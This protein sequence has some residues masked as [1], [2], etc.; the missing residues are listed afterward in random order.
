[1]RWVALILF[2]LIGAVLVLGTAVVALGA[3]DPSPQQ[4]TDAVAAWM[5]GVL[6]APIA[7]RQVVVTTA[8]F[9]T[10]DAGEYDP[11]SD[12]IRLS[13]A[14]S[15]WSPAG[16][17]VRIH[18]LAHREETIAGCYVQGEEA[19]VD[20]VDR[21]LFPAAMRHFFPAG[22]A[23]GTPHTSYDARGAWGPSVSDVRYAVMRATG[24]RT[25]DY[26]ARSYLRR[27]WGA[28]CATRASMLAV[29]A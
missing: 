10:D 3:T 11:V 2:C 6:H 20:A 21:D 18:E 5:T 8:M 12:Q 16:L 4:S 27:V 15:G 1:M 9:Q 22:L 19:I 14:Y 29:G 7:S 13:P 28:D 23:S 24:S 17:F 26:A 25:W